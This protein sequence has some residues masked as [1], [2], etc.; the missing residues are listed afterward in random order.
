M[1]FPSGGTTETPYAVFS[2]SGGYLA[3]SVR[4]T[5]VVC[6]APDWLT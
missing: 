6:L 4:V 3:H 2:Y 5:L 1:A